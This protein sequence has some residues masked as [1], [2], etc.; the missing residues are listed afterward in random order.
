M[1]LNIFYNDE[2]QSSFTQLSLDENQSRQEIMEEDGLEDVYEMRFEE[3]SS[4]EV[5][6]TFSI[7]A[8][9]SSAASD[10]RVSKLDN[11]KKKNVFLIISNIKSE[12]LARKL[13]KSIMKL[14]KFLK[15]RKTPFQRVLVGVSYKLQCDSDI[16][17]FNVQVYSID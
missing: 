11:Y 16:E 5:E 6:S 8:N 13:C 1:A 12:S 14:E 10:R 15:S 2:I 9:L 3:D 17:T 7:Q 4:Q